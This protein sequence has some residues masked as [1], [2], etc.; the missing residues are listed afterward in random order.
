MA[1]IWALL[2]FVLAITILV[3]V[4]EFGH[5]WVARLV[6]IKVLRFSIGF[7]KPIWSF[8]DR[9]GTEF[10]VALIPLGGY[11]KMLDEREGEVPPDELHLA[12][13]RKSIGR[14]MA[15]I[16]AGPLFNILFA[17]VAFWLMLSVGIKSVAPVIGAVLPQSIAAKA[18]LKPM[19]EIIGIDGQQTPSWYAVQMGL[20][21]HIGQ[22]DQA[23]MLVKK[24]KT[25]VTKTHHLDLSQWAYRANHP[26]LLASLGIEPYTPPIPS[27][28]GHVVPNS[29]A[30]KAGLL[31]GDKITAIDGQKVTGWLEMVQII[32]D[33][34]NQ[35]VTLTLLRQ[36]HP[37]TKSVVVGSVPTQMGKK[38][39]F[40]G[41]GSLQ[42]HWPKELIRTQRVNVF[43]AMPLAV[44][45][46]WE[47]THL[48][49]KIL[50]KMV[51]G[52]IS[53]KGLS[54]PIGIAQGAGIS[55]RMGFSYFLN[56]LAL[57]SIGLAII[58]ILPI[59]ILDGGQF[60][61]CLIELITR[62]PVSER[63]QELGLKLGIVLLL[64]VM[65]LALY[66]DISRI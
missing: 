35:T 31:P 24:L 29:P 22:Q 19:E 46:T 66:N 32:S 52:A 43:S 15:V 26:N 59:P 34:P 62:K 30:A 9:K 42:I 13:N 47:I 36:G 17:I 41:I 33:K 39:G 64:G 61:F 21:S 14:R 6:G 28:V 23:T 58:N 48:T 54:G 50:A 5:F 10:A 20:L 18:G 1:V 4:H 56:F 53:T 55:V 16:A 3:A 51:T 45:K 63:V 7:G 40:L 2:G 38:E 57:V 60:L 65:F 11:V 49:C 8:F 44:K 12:F 37:L 27:I 25:T